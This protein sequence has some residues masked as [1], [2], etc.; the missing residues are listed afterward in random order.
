MSSTGARGKNGTRMGSSVSQTV[1]QNMLKSKRDKSSVYS[2]TLSS[3]GTSSIGGSA[4]AQ[5]GSASGGASQGMVHQPTGY[6]AGGVGTSVNRVQASR[7]VAQPAPYQSEM[8]TSVIGLRGY[9]P[10][11]MSP[12]N[13]VFPDSP[14]KKDNL[15]FYKNEISSKPF[16]GT[17][18]EDMLKKWKGD[19]HKLE[20]E[21]QYIQWLFPLPEGKGLNS[22]A[23][24]L[25]QHEA[26]AIQTDLHLKL[27][28]LRAYRMMLDFYGIKLESSETGEVTRAD[29]YKERFDHLNRS[30]H[31][32]RR[33]TRII[34]SIG[35]LGY[36]HLQAPFVKFL[37]YEACVQK[38]L[39]KIKG[40]SIH[41]WIDA[42]SEDKEREE[43]M[44]F[45]LDVNHGDNYFDDYNNVDSADEAV[46]DMGDNSDNI[47]SER[48]QTACT[49]E[50]THGDNGP[51]DKNS[52]MLGSVGRT[53]TSNTHRDTRESVGQSSNSRPKL[54]DLVTGGP[55]VDPTVPVDWN[56]F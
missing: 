35:C 12:S 2:S 18:I 24:P 33:I 28:V 8:G 10:P 1:Q 45:F 23:Q 26:I 46:E 4:T 9:E 7:G 6:H 22:W 5:H 49:L 25:Q 43:T 41:H 48:F 11:K 15:K 30:M 39:W 40:G 50:N 37:I 44:K 47:D 54:I 13:D 31:N 42:I 16:P 55:A 29:N 52:D 19:Y 3:A 34:K 36:G 51:L 32:Y 38:T 21:H 56:Y 14:K 20:Y 17:K 27:R 53:S